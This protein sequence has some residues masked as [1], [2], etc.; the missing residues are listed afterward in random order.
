MNIE[1]LVD[2]VAASAQRELAKTQ[3]TLGELIAAL[4]AIP[5][6]AVVADLRGPHSY[7]GHYCDL[8]LSHHRKAWRYACDLLAD[9]RSAMG[10]EFKGYKGGEFLMGPNTPVWV[11]DYGSCGVKLMGVHQGGELTLGSE[12]EL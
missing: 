3:M 9:C 6:G 8:A 2:G 10:K 7:R 11:A 4:E 12:E 1:H 5:P